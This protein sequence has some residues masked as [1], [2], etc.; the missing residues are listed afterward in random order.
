M[1]NIINRN[2]YNP[3]RLTT[4]E[5]EA[6]MKRLILTAMAMITAVMVSGAAM[7]ATNTMTVSASVTGTCRFSS[8]V[9]TLAFGAL[10]P[11][12]AADGAGSVNI[13]FWC[14]RGTA[15]SM[16]NDD[17]LYETGVNANRMRHAVNP[18]EF[19]PYSISYAAAGTGLGATT[20][21]TLTVSGAIL[22]ADYIN[23]LEGAYSDTVVLTVAP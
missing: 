19:I 20:P 12:S 4:K 15:Y 18:A 13:N 21:I 22:N 8:P 6:N 17:G 10:D 23:A 1:L 3:T 7:A 11:S 9:S 14:T 5:E 16:T 2:K